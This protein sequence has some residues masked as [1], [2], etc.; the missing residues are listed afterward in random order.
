MNDP[1]GGGARPSR[2]QSQSTLFY[3]YTLNDCP[4]VSLEIRTAA[5]QDLLCSARCRRAFTLIELLVVIAIIAIL[6]ALLLPA[7]AHA[8]KEAQRINCLNNL[9]EIGILFQIYTDDH[10]DLFPPHFA[11]ASRDISN[12][13]ANAIVGS[14][15]VPKQY[16]GTFHCPSLN[17]TENAVGEVLKWEFNA[18]NIGYG[19]NAYFLGEFPETGSWS[20]PAPYNGNAWL[21]TYPACKRSQVRHPTQCLLVGDSLKKNPGTVGAGGAFSLDLWWPNA[22]MQKGDGNEGVDIFRHAPYGNVVFT[23]GHGEARKDAQI[24][25]P[26][27]PNLNAPTA[28]VNSHWWDPLQRSMQ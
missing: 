13:W 1:S 12:F 21:Q 10:H 20:A 26:H 19:Y 16:A 15:T 7:L 6:A 8:K 17:G 4:G 14:P 23:D 27:S 28:L 11:D 24:N 22:G 9:H 25:P 3:M 2:T 5:T 18:L